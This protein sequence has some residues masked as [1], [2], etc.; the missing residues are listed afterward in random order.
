MGDFLTARKKAKKVQEKQARKNMF[1]SDEE[2][3][4]LRRKGAEV[5]AAKVVPQKDGT[6]L[7][8]TYAVGSM[9]WESPYMVEI[10]DLVGTR[11]SCSC[12]DYEMNRLGTCK[13]IE[14]TLQYLA[15]RGTKRAFATEGS[16]GSPFYEVFMDATCYP[17]QLRL[18]RPQ[19]LNDVIE[20]RIG[21]FFGSDGVALGGAVEAYHSVMGRM[22]KRTAHSPRLAQEPAA[23]CTSDQ[24][25]GREHD[26]TCHAGK[27]GLQ[28]ESLQCGAR[29]G[30]VA[31]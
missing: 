4:E 18:L 24:S 27:V 10:R 21:V 11:K 9:Q 19:K 8:G 28:A 16:V 5:Q 31:G 17:P 25:R 7:F 23:A 1:P 30:G 3:I 2:S 20:T 6:G 12:N 14:R 26:R 29:W 13:H 22:A 15:K